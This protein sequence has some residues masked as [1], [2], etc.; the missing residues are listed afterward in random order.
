MRLERRHRADQHARVLV[1]R[2]GEHVE[3]G[4]DL[5]QPPLAQHRDAVRDLGDDAEVMRHEK[6]RHAVAPLQ[7]HDQFQDLRLRRDV[8]RGG[9]LVRDEQRRLQ[10]ERH[11]DADTLA[12]A[13]RELVRI[14]VEQSLGIRQGHFAK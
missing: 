14:G 6:H 7:L 3:L 9:R 5:D 4:A 10:R 2:P 13:A 12:L 8:E 1:L 11:R